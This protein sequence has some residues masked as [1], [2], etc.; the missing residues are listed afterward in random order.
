MS[1]LDLSNRDTC[2]QQFLFDVEY[3]K[4]TLTGLGF[5]SYEGLRTYL[6]TGSKQNIFLQGNLAYALQNNKAE[7]VYVAD[8]QQQ[9]EDTL[10]VELAKY[11]FL[12]LKYGKQTE[13]IWTKFGITQ[14]ES[15]WVDIVRKVLSGK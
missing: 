4:Q 7:Y 2:P 11:P 6:I 5:W 12:K 13:V 1:I 8:L 14:A 9:L 15:E 3:P 10:K